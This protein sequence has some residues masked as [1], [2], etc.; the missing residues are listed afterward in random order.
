MTT[1]TKI[2][3]QIYQVIES[4]PAE[5]LPRLLDFVNALLKPAPSSPKPP[6]APIYKIHEHA[7]DTGISDLAA[8][9]DH[10]LYGVSKK[11]A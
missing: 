10:Y 5:Q 2:K 6:I 1:N 8:E 11:D 7:V 4:L 3:Q 9:H